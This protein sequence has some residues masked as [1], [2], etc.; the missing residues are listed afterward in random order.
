MTDRLAKYTTRMCAGCRNDEHGK[1]CIEGCNIYHCTKSHSVDSCADCAE[2][3]CD[4]VSEEVFSPI[5]ISAWKN[6]NERIREVGIEQYCI[7]AIATPHYL[8]F[9]DNE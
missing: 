7:E 5:V 1:C 2:F 4:K 3:P 9:K 8:A 6:G